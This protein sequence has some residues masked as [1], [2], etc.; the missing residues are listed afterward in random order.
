MIA[1]TSLATDE[2]YR[3]VADA[4]RSLRTALRQLDRARRPPRDLAAEIETALANGPLTVPE[5]G[6]TIRA[7]HSDI[8]QILRK[9]PQRFECVQ[10]VPGR[11]PKAKCWKNAPAASR[12][13]PDTPAD[14]LE[15][16]RD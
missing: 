8:R 11:S 3:L 5:L 2:L 14:S 10:N 12:S 15:V 9:H 4:E 7:R 16:E 1:R 13:R 6:K